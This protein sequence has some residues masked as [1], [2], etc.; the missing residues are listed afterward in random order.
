MHDK[1]RWLRQSVCNLNNPV[2]AGMATVLAFTACAASS[3]SLD[4]AEVEATQQA[5]STDRHYYATQL[6]VGPWLSDPSVLEDYKYASTIG[7]RDSYTRKLSD[8]HFDNCYWTE[9]RNWVINHRNSAVSWAIA[10]WNGTPNA[11]DYFFQSLG[12]T[13]HAVQDF[14]AHSNWVADVNGGA[15]NADSGAIVD[16]DQHVDSPFAS[17]YSFTYENAN[18]TGPNAGELHC[19]AGSRHPHSS[20]TLDNPGGWDHDRALIDAAAATFDQVRRFVASLCAATSSCQDILAGLGIGARPSTNTFR[21]DFQREVLVPGGPWG[22]PGAAVYCPPGTYAGAF[23]QRVEPSQGAGDDTALNAIRLYCYDR[24][25]GSESVVDSWDG[26]W[27]TWGNRV[28]C[29]TAGSFIV[30]GI[31]KVEGQQ[32]GGDDTSANAAA[33]YCNDGTLLQTDNEG[34][35]GDWVYPWT[36]CGPNEA[37]CGARSV[38][39]PPING[40]DTAL[41]AVYLYCCSL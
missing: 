32:Y 29:S 11:R 2:S 28:A 37:V 5:L 18:D 15:A 30:A 17:W 22:E 31:L 33:F 24:Y 13:L 19:P 8:A 25:G 12:F 38:V 26:V 14:Y 35:W 4:E 20:Y 41:N 36:G 40:D 9:G 16:F 21:A 10:W 39:E 34:P 7:D 3:P 23:Q 6:G 27:G 1:T